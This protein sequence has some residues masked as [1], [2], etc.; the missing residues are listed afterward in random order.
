MKVL[1]TGGAGFIGSNVIK[2][3]LS[4][5]II[6]RVLDN[7]SSGYIDNLSGYNVEFIEGDVCDKKIV[8]KA[9][10]GVEAVFHFAASVGRQRSIDDPIQDSMTNL[11]GTITLLESMRANNV[12]KIIYSSSAAIFGELLTETI[13]ENHPL[14]PD[15]PYGVSKLAAEKMILSYANL[16]D[17]TAVCLRYFNIYG[18]NQRYDFYGN[19]I[20]NFANKLSNNLPII[21]FG[22]GEQ[23]RDFLNVHDVAQANYLGLLFNGKSDVYNIGSGKSI[24]INDLA[25][26]MIKS[27]GSG[28]IE[29]RPRRP[30]DVLHCKAEISRSNSILGFDP[31]INLD[32]G[33]TNYIS[34][35]KS[36]TG[37]I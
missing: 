5:G 16:Y 24:T 3:L 17:M 10:I 32:D 33:L 18:E 29:Y 13:D 35:Y 9:C 7:L 11:I 25:K 23:T 8:M 27:F 2:L 19:V 12:K 15:S 31:L 6:V 14:N 34:W 30:A 37:S 28:S 22:D 20:P 26:K 1:V 4:K 21:I 36:S